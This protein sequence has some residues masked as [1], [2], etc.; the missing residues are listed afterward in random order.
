MGAAPSSRILP[1]LTCEELAALAEQNSKT[2]VAIIVRENEID[3]GFLEELD[4]ETLEELEPRK[5]QRLKFKSALKQLKEHFARNDLIVAAPAAGSAELADFLRER[6]DNPTIIRLYVVDRA[7][8]LRLARDWKPGAHLPVYQDLRK[9]ID[10]LKCI[11]VDKLD[12]LR[13]GGLEGVLAVSYTWESHGVPDSEGARLRAVALYLQEHPEIHSVWFDFMCLPQNT[14]QPDKKTGD[15]PEVPYPVDYTRNEFEEAYFDFILKNAVNILYLSASVLSIVNAH[16][17]QRFWPQFEYYLG[18][19]DVCKGG[20]RPSKRRSVVR[21]IES[22]EGTDDATALQLQAKWHELSAGQAKQKLTKRD[23]AAANN[24]D[25]EIMAGKLEELE[26]YLAE[27]VRDLPDPPEIAASGAVGA[28]TPEAVAMVAATEATENMDR[29]S[30]AEAEAVGRQPRERQAAAPVSA[31]SSTFLNSPG[32]W[33][34]F[35]SHTQRDAEA[36][37]LAS[38]LRAD[39]EKAGYRIWLDVKMKDLSMAAMKEGVKNSEIFIAIITAA[40]FTREF[41]IAELRWAREAGKPIQP[42]IRAEDKQR[43]GEFLDMAPADLKDIG[44][45][46]FIHLDRGDIEYWELGVKKVLSASPFMLPPYSPPPSITASSTDGPKEV[47]AEAKS[48]SSG[49]ADGDGADAARKVQAIPVYACVAIQ[50]P[51]VVTGFSDNHAMFW[52]RLKEIE[53]GFV[54]SEHAWTKTQKIPVLLSSAKQSDLFPALRMH[55]ARVLVWCAAGCGWET[56]GGLPGAAALTPETLATL[57]QE[58]ASKLPPAIVVVCMRH[59]ARRA[60]K[61]LAGA[62]PNSVVAWIKTDVLK[63]GGKDAFFRTIVPIVDIAETP[64]ATES[65]MQAKVC[66]TFPGKEAGFVSH[67]A[68]GLVPWEPP[69]DSASQQH[70][71]VYNSAPFAHDTNI[72]RTA[73]AHLL[74]SDSEY[75]QRVARRLESSARKASSQGQDTSAVVLRVCGGSASR[76]RS[77]AADACLSLV[78]R[79]DSEFSCI[80]RS[81]SVDE[82]LAQRS[83]VTKSSSQKMLLWIDVEGASE[84]RDFFEGNQA[85]TSTTTTILLT[86]SDSEREVVDQLSEDFDFDEEK[87][88]PVDEARV[89][90]ASELHG[91][92]KLSL[93]VAQNPGISL[94]M[95]ALKESQSLGLLDLF[96]GGIK[97]AGELN[98]ILP[99]AQQVAAIFVDEDGGAVV[100]WNVSSVGHLHQLRDMVLQGEI[101]E[102]LTDALRAR[103]DV[104]DVASGV[105]IRADKTAFARQY[106]QS[107]LML[108]Q[109]TPH[110]E[111][112]LAECRA[113]VD[114]VHIQAPAGAGKTFVALHRILEMLKEKESEAIILFVARNPAL[115]VFV[116][117]WLNERLQKKH[118]GFGDRKREKKLARVHALFHP[119][120]MGPRSAGIDRGRIAFKTASEAT[121]SKPYSL[122]V[123]D[124]AHHL[125]RD[126]QM[127]VAIEDFVTPEA[128]RRLLLSDISQSTLYA[129]PYPKNMQVVTLEEVVRCSKRVVA[130]AM[131]FQVG[132]DKLLTKCHHDSAGPP[133]KSFLFD[134]AQGGDLYARYAVET[135]KALQFIMKTFP[136]LML[137][138]RLAIVLP[139]ETFA[140]T[141]MRPLSSLLRDRFQDR[142]FALVD[143]EESSSLTTMDDDEEETDGAL[144]DAA[145]AEAILFDSIDN[146]DGLE[147]LIVIGVGLDAKIDEAGS[148]DRAGDSDRSSDLDTRS[149]IYRALTRAHMM[150]TLV[151]EMLPGGWL[152]FINGLSLERRFDHDRELALA[153]QN[154]AAVTDQKRVLVKLVSDGE[155][156]LT[157]EEPGWMATCE[158]AGRAHDATQAAD[159][160]G[161]G[162]TAEST[163]L[164][165]LLEKM[166]PRILDALKDG[167]AIAESGLSPDPTKSASELFEAMRILE[168]VCAAAAVPP[169]AQE[170]IDAARF[171]EAARS[172]RVIAEAKRALE[173]SVAA[174]EKAAAVA[175]S[176]SSTSPSSLNSSAARRAILD[177]RRAL[178]LAAEASGMESSMLRRP[179]EALE[180]SV[181]TAIEKALLAPLPQFGT[182]STASELRGVVASLEDLTK[183]AEL[184]PHQLDGRTIEG[185]RRSLEEASDLQSAHEG[186]ERALRECAEVGDVQSGGEE[187]SSLEPPLLRNLASKCRALQQA[188]DA[189]ARASA[190]GISSAPEAAELRRRVE[191]MREEARRAMAAACEAALSMTITSA[192]AEEE[193]L[194]D[195]EKTLVLVLEL[196]QDLSMDGGE[197]VLFSEKLEEV[198]AVLAASTTKQ[199]VW[200][201]EHN[202]T[203]LKRSGKKLAFDPHEVAAEAVVQEQQLSEEEQKKVDKELST[204]AYN[205]DEEGVRDLLAKGANPN[206]YKDVR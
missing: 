89:I 110:Q 143:A 38:E 127:R 48:A 33:K 101:D 28:T 186:L 116:A 2:E 192:A 36:K 136:G 200:D 58:H 31:S 10:D 138:G 197:T 191:M 163:A 171:R 118:S 65:D 26:K 160:L 11:K 83:R 166:R 130:G 69:S 203:T 190:V 87:L 9:K 61:I 78:V 140:R 42:V 44:K 205:G 86:S 169:H 15:M 56:N 71:T 50:P 119:F 161:I 37:L 45:I 113:S 19:R 96:G 145:R 179:L 51:A 158:Y 165:N 159:R 102:L 54:E 109:L 14:N 123:V 149:K 198:R 153:R 162:R 103:R 18:T 40:Y 129:I 173:Q 174:V 70:L 201:A 85:L 172:I 12:A 170:T 168:V 59:G 137:H 67:V 105:R 52:N 183:G 147:R 16:Y 176:V 79:S 199:S 77:I 82:A 151:N 141:F 23:V 24:S 80:F 167:A 202:T 124:E 17:L 100:R 92:F 148:G 128:T 68:P 1:D 164:A 204:A 60:A 53:N 8:F 32:R 62:L 121:A 34:F 112:K 4:D 74:A 29:R 206:G 188:A 41:C 66:S 154:A 180:Q 57:F 94:K 13:N 21:C 139:D 115:C 49:D 107:I 30:S 182:S 125:Y 142:A 72:D 27:L 111:A 150:V 55:R 177:G 104:G 185:F 181:L 156:L 3:G 135:V 47:V 63:D 7:V 131:A 157:N 114:D 20:F 126:D 132:G 93:N 91:E 106:E 120:S 178:Q 117:K 122:L 195:A 95:D 189:A 155:A 152:E 88:Q 25:K 134:N 196:A 108:D 193:G 187:G 81:T 194:L 146:V 35:A 75:A 97:L 6:Q 39:C 46:N 144:S 64:G 99:G 175:S 73:S 43:I 5:V 84:W 184:F 90:K 22:Q 98:Q 76:C 133:L